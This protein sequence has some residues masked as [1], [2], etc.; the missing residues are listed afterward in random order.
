MVIDGNEGDA[1][2]CHGSNHGADDAA[3]DGWIYE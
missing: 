1:D 3:D 2:G